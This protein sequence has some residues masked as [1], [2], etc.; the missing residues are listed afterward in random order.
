MRW[1]DGTRWTDHTADWSGIRPTATATPINQPDLAHRLEAERRIVPWL[2]ALLFVWPIG[3]ALS[4][5]GLG[6]TFDDL[7]HG[8]Q[9]S[10]PGFSWIGPPGG[11]GGRRGSLPRGPG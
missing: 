4:L 7:V 2:R 10:G 6:S 9:Q 1:W 5:G 8:D 3:V 11:A